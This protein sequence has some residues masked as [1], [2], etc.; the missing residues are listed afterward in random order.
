[1]MKN[2]DKTKLKTTG[3]VVA[4]VGA[5]AALLALALFTPVFS[6]LGQIG[7]FLGKAAYVA[8]QGVGF[9]LKNPAAVLGG[10]LATSKKLSGK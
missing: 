10:Y 5:T 8:A 6:I 9:A 7:G 1:M 2:I 4:G 3:K